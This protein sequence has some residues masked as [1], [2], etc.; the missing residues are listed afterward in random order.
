MS[1]VPMTGK[2]N[3]ADSTT[4]PNAS[5]GP[6]SA[7][8]P[9]SVRGAVWRGPGQ[10]VVE[11][12]A[13][14][15]CPPG[16]VLLEP[17]RV[18]LCGTDLSIV[19]G[20]HGRA[21][22]PLVLGHEIVGTVRHSPTGT[23][24]PGSRVVVNPL[25]P[26]GTCWPCRNDLAHTCRHLRLVGID[27]N[28]ALAE[29]V[30]VPAANLL[31]VSPVTAVD[32]A[33][34]T[35][36]LAVA[37]HAVRRA[38]LEEDQTVVVVGAG[39]IGVLI[40]LVAAA[41]K[42][43]VLISEPHPVRR[44]AASRLGFETLPSDTDPVEALVARTDGVMGDVVFDCAGHPTVA[45]QLSALTRVRGTIVIAG[46]YS[47]PAPVDLHAVTF[48]EQ[49][50]VG[51]RVYTEA[52]FSSALALIEQG[53]LDLPRL[54]VKTFPLDEVRAA[55]RSAQQ[56]EALKVLISPRETGYEAG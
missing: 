34:L 4:H 25:L 45:A 16:W 51:S 21:A 18:G 17:E 47:T 50:I 36:P 5:A 14:P 12:V 24:Q 7:Q 46:L 41:T 1:D 33:A 39:P 11:E 53:T 2:S 23:P 8:P 32:E 52:D 6:V 20:K 15:T 31:A 49:Q 38:A 55:F 56:G 40:A 37:V 48:A 9:R 28:G 44:E 54:D 26:C 43:R 30:A 19:A 22:A 10:L 27:I 3:A 35:E 29:R 42:C 13:S